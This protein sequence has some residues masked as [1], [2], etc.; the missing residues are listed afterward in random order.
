[1]I[2][3]PGPQIIDRGS[4]TLIESP[5][6]LIIERGGPTLIERPSSHS[7]EK[8]TSAIINRAGTS[9]HCTPNIRDSNDVANA[10]VSMFSHNIN[11]VIMGNLFT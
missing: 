3:S 9:P 8:A 4:P 11:V 2:E 1:M 7:V 10:D 5:G 6:P